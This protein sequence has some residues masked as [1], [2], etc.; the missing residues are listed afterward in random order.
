VKRNR[1]LI[2]VGSLA[3]LILGVSLYLYRGNPVC[4][5]DYATFEES[6]AAFDEWLVAYLETN[7]Q[8]SVPEMT[9]ARKQF[10]I[11]NNCTAA[12]ERFEEGARA[13]EAIPAP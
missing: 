4:P 1:I 3:L 10:Y 12:L 5:D 13:N 9:E 11:E 6:S 8:A 2:A 7:P